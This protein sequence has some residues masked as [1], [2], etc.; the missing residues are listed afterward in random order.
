MVHLSAGAV[1]CRDC[2]LLPL[3]PVTAVV[4][5]A[6]GRSSTRP[7][8]SGLGGGG[9][10]SG[11]PFRAAAAAAPGKPSRAAAGR[12]AFRPAGSSGGRPGAVSHG[13]E[14]LTGPLLPPSVTNGRYSTL[15]DT[16]VCHSTSLYITAHYEPAVALAGR[17]GMRFLDFVVNCL[18]LLTSTGHH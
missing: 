17:S 9:G 11:R 4:A 18:L 10:R 5:A 7:L 16:T 3:S 8:E 2:H 12:A 14:L 6:V 15:M 1:T 13:P